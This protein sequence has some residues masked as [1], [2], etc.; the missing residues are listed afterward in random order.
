MKIKHKS[1]GFDELVKLIAYY[2]EKPEDWLKSIEPRWAYNT[3]SNKVFDPDLKEDSQYTFFLV[4]P[5]EIIANAEFGSFNKD[6]LFTGE[7]NNDSRIARILYYWENGFYIDPP[8]IVWSNIFKHIYFSDGRHRTKLA[9]FIDR[10]T[11]PIATD[12]M[13]FSEINRIVKLH[14]CIK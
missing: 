14:L 2:K 13:D 6:S 9:F 7:W 8:T 5:S 11:I 12:P 10:K 1:L 4:D 3:H